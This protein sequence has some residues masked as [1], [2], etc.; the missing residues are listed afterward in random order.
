MLNALFKVSK[1]VSST[2]ANETQMVSF[3]A[4]TTRSLLVLQDCYAEINV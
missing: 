4:L 2:A 3:S 1:E